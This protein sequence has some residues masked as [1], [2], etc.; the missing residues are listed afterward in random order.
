M[1]DNPSIRR[2]GGAIPTETHSQAADET[3][4][5]GDFVTKNL[6][7]T[8]AECTATSAHIYGRAFA[9]LD[10]RFT[11]DLALPDVLFP[12]TA[13]ADASAAI[14]KLVDIAV[15]N[16]TGEHQANV[17]GTSHLVL[18]IDSLVPNAV[19]DKTAIYVC[20]PATK[21]QAVEVAADAA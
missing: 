7:G 6:D 15:N 8:I 21:S 11:V 3:L 12:V 9:T 5:D 19:V 13:T 20:V 2:G 10:G 14:G 16:T 4:K 1:F 17:S 18:M